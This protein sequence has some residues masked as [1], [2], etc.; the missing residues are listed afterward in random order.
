MTPEKFK[1]DRRKLR[2]TQTEMAHLFG[3]RELTVARWEKGQ[4]RIPI[5][6]AA[7]VEGMRLENIG[8]QTPPMRELLS[9]V[10][11]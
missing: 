8:R 4:S 6:V 1:A 10:R 11:T 3:V 9:A 2:M 5:T 7:L